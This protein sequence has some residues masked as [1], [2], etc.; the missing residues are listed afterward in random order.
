VGY[1]HID[2]K[3]HL[4]YLGLRLVFV[5]GAVVVVIGVVVG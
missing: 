1:Y 3:L 4:G 5:I 2:I